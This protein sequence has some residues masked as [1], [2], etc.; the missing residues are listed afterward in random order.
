MFVNI[1]NTFFI[2]KKISKKKLQECISFISNQK[3]LENLVVQNSYK[4]NISKIIT[5]PY[6]ITNKDVDIVIRTKFNK[7]YKFVNLNKIFSQ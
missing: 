3:N 4:N 7:D 6:G 5:L 1:D 2:K